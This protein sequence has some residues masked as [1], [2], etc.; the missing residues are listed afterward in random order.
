MTVMPMLS[1]SK[2]QPTALTGTEMELS[3]GKTIG[4]LEE[5]EEVATTG[6]E[7]ESST[8]KMTSLQEVSSHGTVTGSELTG[9][10]TVLLTG[11]MDGEEWIILGPPVLG[12][13]TGEEK[14]GDQKPSQ[15]EK[16][17][18]S[19]HGTIPNGKL[20]MDLGILTAGE[21]HG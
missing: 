19:A 11:K 16:L 17:M 13:L 2:D 20:L 6:T 9:T 14:D 15:S 21:A 12:T 4:P 18:L 5:A 7:M 3:T 1:S 8:G 10:E